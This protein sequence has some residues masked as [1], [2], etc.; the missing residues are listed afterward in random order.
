MGIR[1]ASLV[2]LIVRVVVVDLGLEQLQHQSMPR[3]SDVPGLLEQLGCLF[4][5]RGA[6]QEVQCPRVAFLLLQ[7]WQ[8]ASFSLHFGRYCYICCQLDYTF[9]VCCGF[10]RIIRVCRNITTYVCVYIYI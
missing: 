10:L 5:F 6:R 2:S 9:C 4:A 3:L 1:T 7:F 8:G